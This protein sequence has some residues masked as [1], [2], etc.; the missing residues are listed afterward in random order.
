MKR[1]Q[2]RALSRDLFFNLQCT[3][4]NPQFADGPIAYLMKTTVKLTGYCDDNFFDNVNAEPSEGK[5]RVC[6]RRYRVQWFRDGIEAE[7]I[8]DPVAAAEP[9]KAESSAP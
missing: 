3:C 2:F 6:G 1:Q 5:C 9:S 4:P 8:D 7:F